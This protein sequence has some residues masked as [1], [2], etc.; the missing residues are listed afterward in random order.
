[1]AFCLW[2]SEWWHRNYEAGAWKWMPLLTT[3]GTPELAPGGSRYGELQDLVT[4]GLRAW[5]RSVYRVGPSR[6][7]LVTLA[8]EGGLPLKLILREQTHLRRYRQATFGREPRWVV[9]AGLGHRTRYHALEKRGAGCGA[10]SA[11]RPRLNS[12]GRACSFG[13]VGST[14]E[15]HLL[16]G[17]SRRGTPLL[18]ELFGGGRTLAFAVQSVDALTAGEDWGALGESAH[19]VRGTLAAVPGALH[20]VDPADLRGPPAGKVDCVVLS[21]GMGG[22]VSS[23]GAGFWNEILAVAP[24]LAERISRGEPIREVVYQD[25]YVR[26]PLVARLVSE[27]LDELITMADG[28][29]SGARLR[30]VTTAPRRSGRSS[31]WVEDDWATGQEAKKTIERLFSAKSMS[32]D[33]TLRDI[34]RAPHVRECR[35]VWESG[36]VWRCRLDHGFGFV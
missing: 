32:I 14:L 11:P 10:G 35:V 25:R 26:S 34:K 13:D 27:I 17:R 29:M 16:R 12:A 8:C 36:S 4:R 23:F 18:A 30:I 1:M 9:S 22:S 31:R 5:G 28:A 33:L 6:G 21:Q 19:V 7:Y 20:R 15:V 24:G 3:V 2:A